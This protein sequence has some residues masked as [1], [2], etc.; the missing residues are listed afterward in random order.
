MDNILITGGTSGIGL[1]T[2]KLLGKKGNHIIVNGISE[3]QK[4]IAEELLKNEHISFEIVLFDVTNEIQVNKAMLYISDK[5]KSLK[6][7]INCAG[8]LWGRSTIEK[9]DTGF[10]K[11]VIG[12]NVESAF[13]VSRAGLEMLKETEGSSIVNFSSNAAWTSG[14]IGAG[15]YGTSKA[16][17]TTLTRAMAKE[18]SK[19][20][21]RVNAVS[22]GTIDTPFHN[23]IKRTKPELFESWKDGILLGRVG[24]PQEVATVVAFLV[25]ND[26]SFIT[27]EII[28]VN[29]G[30]DFI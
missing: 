26:A 18:F 14:G 5:Y 19:Y 22:P 9:M 3:R 11:K 21:I 4:K 6:A 2:A 7:I 25:S 23:E 16:A 13:Y 12:L 20:G 15:I 28:Q 24:E 17:I 10:F 8:G 30:Q 1:E 27:G 29:G